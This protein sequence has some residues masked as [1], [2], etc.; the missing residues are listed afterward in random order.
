[1]RH[2]FP[3]QIGMYGC[4]QFTFQEEKGKRRSY[5]ETTI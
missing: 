4:Q 5:V 1:M 3:A 2:K